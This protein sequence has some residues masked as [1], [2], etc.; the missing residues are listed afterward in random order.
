MLLLTKFSEVIHV[1]GTNKLLNNCLG[2]VEMLSEKGAVAYKI[3]LMSLTTEADRLPG[4]ASLTVP[5]LQVIT[6][7]ATVRLLA[8]Y[9]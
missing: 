4:L 5:Q 1:W 2:P 3:T 8:G 9:P 7:S 6:Q